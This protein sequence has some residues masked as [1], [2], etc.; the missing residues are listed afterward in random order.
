MSL[1][2]SL[3]RRQWAGRRQAVKAGAIAPPLRGFGL[4][5]LPPTRS[6][7]LQADK[8]VLLALSRSHHGYRRGGAVWVRL[9]STNGCPKVSERADIKVAVVDNAGRKRARRSFDFDEARKQVFYPG[10]LDLPKPG[11]APGGVRTLAGHVDAIDAFDGDEDA[12]RLLG[13]SWL[14]LET[15]FDLIDFGIRVRPETETRPRVS[16][17]SR[18]FR[19]T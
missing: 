12:E 14:G 8:D 17:Y 11:L 15:K 6:G 19:R 7:A 3:C 4:D 1:G 16:A 13:T 2:L 9:A 5:C 10:A 18:Y